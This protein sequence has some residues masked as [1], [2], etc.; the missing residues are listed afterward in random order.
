MT[1]QSIINSVRSHFIHTP[2]PEVSAA[3]E[4]VRA[5]KH[6]TEELNDRLQPYLDQEDPLRALMFDLQL[7]RDRIARGE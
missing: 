1:L 6:R 4:A 5:V 7:R 2:P 3:F